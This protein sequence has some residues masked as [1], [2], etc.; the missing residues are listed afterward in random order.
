MEGDSRSAPTAGTAQQ[1]APRRTWRAT[2]RRAVWRRGVHRRAAAAVVAGAAAW[3]AVA[4]VAPPPPETVRV[5]VA[6]GQIAVGDDLGPHNLT[7]ADLPPDAVPA[8][9]LSSV[10]ELTGARALAPLAGGEVVTDLRARPD[11]LLEG[12]GVDR[13]A[14]YLPLADSALAGVLMPGSRIDLLS[15]ADGTVLAREARVLARPAVSGDGGWPVA[16]AAPGGA[17]VAVS[18][19]EAGRLAV[20]TAAGLDGRAVAVVIHPAEHGPRD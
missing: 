10:T 6:N 1:A 13:V 11:R 20:A 7:T 19:E 17:L 9:A 16:G 5:V 15:T 3:L 18:P 4:Q 12:L 14:A 2:G 8:G